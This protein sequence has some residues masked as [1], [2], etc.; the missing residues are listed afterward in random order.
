MKSPTYNEACERCATLSAI[1]RSIPG[2]DSNTQGRRMLAAMKLLGSVTSYEGS[3]HLDCYDPR[4][5]VYELRQTG[6]RI[7]TLTRAMPTESGVLHYMGE[8][9]YEGPPAYP[10]LDGL[11]GE[12]VSA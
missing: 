12:E 1:L 7:K 8:Y 4:A 11:D 2:N 9:V 6:H 5:R 3:R 10:L